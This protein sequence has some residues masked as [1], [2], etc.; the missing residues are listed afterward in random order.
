M[1]Q[2]EGGGKKISVQSSRKKKLNPKQ[3]KVVQ[4]M[5]LVAVF[6]IS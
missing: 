5:L 4:L 2:E 3:W 6:T 1:G